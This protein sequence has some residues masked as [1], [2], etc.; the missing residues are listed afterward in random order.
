MS[1]GSFLCPLGASC[2]PGD[3]H[4]VNPFRDLCGASRRRE[5][6]IPPPPPR[7]PSSVLAPLLWGLA[8]LFPPTH[9]HYTLP[10]SPAALFPTFLLPWEPGVDVPCPSEAKAMA[11]P[12][13]PPRHRLTPPYLNPERRAAQTA[14]NIPL[15]QKRGFCTWK[16]KR[17]F[18]LWEAGVVPCAVPF[19]WKVSWDCFFSLGGSSGIQLRLL[20]DPR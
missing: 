5:Q 18:R 4:T 6:L 11:L 20:Q 8:P 16:N 19:P 13:V 9:E 3:P 2:T 1:L 10:S 17:C 15:S 7:P 14:F 12:G